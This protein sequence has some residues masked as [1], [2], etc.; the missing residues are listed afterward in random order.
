MLFLHIISLLLFTIDLNSLSEL[1]KQSSTLSADEK[2]EL[3]SQ[4]LIGTPFKESSIGENGGIDDDPIINLE[5]I[6]CVT[7]VEYII[8]FVNSKDIDEFKNHIKLL[9]YADREIN[10]ENRMHLP[11]FQWFPNA[12]RYGY[13]KD[14]TGLIGK[15]Y[16]KKIK[17]QLKK[18]FYIDKQKIDTSKLISDAVEIEYIPLNKLEV[19]YNTIPAHSIIRVIREDSFRPYLTT[20]IGIVIQK[21]KAKYLRHASRHFKEQVVD[22]PLITYFS[23]FSKYKNWKALGVAIYKINYTRKSSDESK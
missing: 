12:Q 14:I 16:T 22:I 2:I 10:F 23:T 1:L 4:R 18:P 5:Y 21:G 8:A 6:D 11:D 17:K 19:I 20:H 15:N 3:I 9:R 13:V 7:F